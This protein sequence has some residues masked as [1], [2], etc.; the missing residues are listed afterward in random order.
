MLLSFSQAFAVTTFTATEDLLV[1]LDTGGTYDLIVV[2]RPLVDTN[3]LSL[4]EALKSRTLEIPLLI[5]S[6]IDDPLP[7]PEILEGSGGGL[8]SKKADS[9]MFLQA[10]EMVLG[11]G[12]FTVSEEHS[13]D[14]VLLD[15]PDGTADNQM[16]LPKL[17]NRQIEILQH[18]RQGMSNKDVALYLS[19]SENT[20]KGHLKLIFC[21]LG[22]GN[23]MA[24]VQKA[25]HYG[26]I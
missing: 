7:V 23:R 14:L 1:D 12:V 21:A 16:L 17:S 22:V 15:L 3:G 4:I 24:C 13:L 8:I 5:M 26:L 19:I 9:V 18:V 25:Q 6:G 20:V 10:V 2:H 11:G